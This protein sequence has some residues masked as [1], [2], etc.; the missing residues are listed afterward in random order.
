[1]NIFVLDKDIQTCSKYHADQHVIKMILESAQMLCTVNHQFGLQAPYKSTHAKH[2]CTL[3]AADSLENWIWLRS[4][5]LHLNEEFRYRFDRQVDHKSAIVARELP[6][7]PI[8][9]KGLTEFAQAM[10]E[11]YRS[12]GNAVKAYRQ[13]YIAEKSKFATWTKRPVPEW[14]KAGCELMKIKRLV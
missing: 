13:F 2:P 9:S 10:P 12:P 3:W 11:E 1:M 5:A 6:V 7:P 14:F 4:L 8:E